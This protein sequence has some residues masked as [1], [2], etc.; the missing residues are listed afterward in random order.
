MDNKNGAAV[1]AVAVDID[2]I[3]AQNDKARKR[4]V[5][6]F[7][8]DETCIV[9]SIPKAELL[10]LVGPSSTGK[11]SGAVVAI[12]GEFTFKHKGQEIPFSCSTGWRGCWMTV[13]R[14][15]S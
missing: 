7:D 9:L 12:D 5:A 3:K 10:S 1:A 13:Y 2:A 8:E 11:G 14:K 15:E 4:V 6:V